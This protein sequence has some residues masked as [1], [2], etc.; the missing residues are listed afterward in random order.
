MRIDGILQCL[1]GRRLESKDD[2]WQEG[3]DKEEHGYHFMVEL[4]L[5]WRGRRGKG[6]R[7]SEEI[8]KFLQVVGDMGREGYGER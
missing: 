4:G 2:P 5:K 7:G 6:S 1:F 8:W 3:Q